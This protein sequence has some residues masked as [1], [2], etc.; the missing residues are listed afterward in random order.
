MT[1]ARLH[2]R[3]WR[4]RAGITQ[5]DVAKALGVRQATVS[6]LERGVARTVKLAHLTKLARLF[7]CEPWELL[8]AP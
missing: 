1:E 3:E 5:G 8:R 6:D 4:E 7:R 2:L